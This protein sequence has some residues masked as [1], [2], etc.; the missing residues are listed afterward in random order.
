M[1]RLPCQAL[2]SVLHTPLLIQLTRTIEVGAVLLLMGNLSKLTQLAMG[3]GWGVMS[4]IW[5]V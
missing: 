5:T 3:M 4:W 2:C 1:L